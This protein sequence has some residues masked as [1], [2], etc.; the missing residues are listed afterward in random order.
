MHGCR[1]HLFLGILKNK[2]IFNA[3]ETVKKNVFVV[4]VVVIII[5]IIIRVC[6]GS[7]DL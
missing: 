7:Q 1:K 6:L 3:D 2:I 5:N 4:V